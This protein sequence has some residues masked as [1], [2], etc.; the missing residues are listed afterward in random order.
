VTGS[1]KK[2]AGIIQARM[3]SRRLPGKVMMDL[4]GKTLLSRVIDRTRAAKRIDSI[5]VATSAFPEDDVIEIEARRNDVEVFRGDLD[6]VLM[7]YCGAADYMGAD[8]V[9]R[10]TGDNPLT[11][12]SFIDM[13]SDKILNEDLDYVFVSDVPYGSGAEAISR[14]ALF[15]ALAKADSKEKEHVTMY[16]YKN[17]EDFKNSTIEPPP[18][19]RRPDIRLTIDTPKDYI[20]LRKVFSYFYE[21]GISNIGLRAVIELID[22]IGG[23]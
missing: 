4:S 6:N 9:L 18:W 5:C 20:F 11:E 1:E 3:S 13:C 21:K 12:P 16:L 22:E 2:V 14:R 15:E 8:Y 19:L 10:I 17:P 7:R 23:A